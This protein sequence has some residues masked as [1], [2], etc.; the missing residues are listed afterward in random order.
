MS[1]LTN[2]GNGHWPDFLCYSDGSEYMEL[3]EV[4]AETE[5]H[6]LTVRTP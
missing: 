3:M 2:A 4:M 1:T 5:T 6:V